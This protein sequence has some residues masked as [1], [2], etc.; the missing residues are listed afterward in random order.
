MHRLFGKPS[1]GGGADGRKKSKN[2]NKDKDDENEEEEPA[3]P[4][5][6]DAAAKMDERI[7]ALDAKIKKVNQEL[8]GYKEQMKKAKPGPKASIQKRALLALERRKQYESQ[9][10]KMSS[11]QFNIERTAFAI[12]QVQDT[13]QAVAAMQAATE[14]LK[15]ETGKIDLDEIED[16]QDDLADLLEDQDEIQDILAEVWATPDGALDEDDLEAELAGLEDEF[17]GIDLEESVAAPVSLPTNPTQPTTVFN[18]GQEVASQETEAAP[19]KAVDEF[20]LPV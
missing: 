4:T 8:L 1:A 10:D 5:L 16:M 11:Q 14:T 13:Q 19:K 12:E 6:G 18:S 2:E 3:K 20:G 17:E 15:I 9:R 7:A